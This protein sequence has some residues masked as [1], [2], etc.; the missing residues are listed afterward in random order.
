MNPYFMGFSNVGKFTLQLTFL[1][2]LIR[3]AKENV[4]EEK[5]Y[6]EEI[7]YTTHNIQTTILL[8]NAKFSTVNNV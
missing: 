8:R 4:L 1:N 6:V 5:H 3:V 7:K 2:N